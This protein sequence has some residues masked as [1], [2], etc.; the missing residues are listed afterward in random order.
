MK[1]SSNQ[2]I[3]DEDYEILRIMKIVVEYHLFYVKL[4]MT[5]SSHTVMILK[6]FQ[7]I[8]FFYFFFKTICNAKLLNYVN[9]KKMK[10]LYFQLRREHNQYNNFVKVL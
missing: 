2:F 10:T 7:I 4:V 5:E 8:F 3:I 9:V 1:K 6:S